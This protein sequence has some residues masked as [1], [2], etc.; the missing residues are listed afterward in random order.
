M[1]AGRLSSQILTSA[2]SR[3][4]PRLRLSRKRAQR[5]IPTPIAALCHAMGG[6]QA[7]SFVLTFLSS[8]PIVPWQ[9][10]LRTSA[11]LRL[12]CRVRRIRLLGQRIEEK[13]HLQAAFLVAHDLLDDRRRLVRVEQERRRRSVQCNGD[14]FQVGQLDRTPASFVV[15]RPM[16]RLLGRCVHHVQDRVAIPTPESDVE[17]DRLHALCSRLLALENDFLVMCRAPL[18]AAMRTA[19]RAPGAGLR[20]LAEP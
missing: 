9:C 20:R 5:T 1:R 6:N 14:G 10:R 7:A 13:Q 11:W 19:A 15:R 2:R 18:L 17:R 4:A 3:D 8:I 16:D 12:G